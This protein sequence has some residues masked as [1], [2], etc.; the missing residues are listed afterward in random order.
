M[1]AESQFVSVWLGR[2]AWMPGVSAAEEK[3]RTEK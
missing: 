3:V 1:L 2:W